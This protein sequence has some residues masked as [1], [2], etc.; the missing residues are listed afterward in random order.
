MG[1]LS[2][3]LARLVSGGSLPLPPPQP[4]PPGGLAGALGGALGQQ[5]HVARLLQAQ[6]AAMQQQIQ[7]PGHVFLP[8]LGAITRGPM[9]QA[10]QVRGIEGLPPLDV[11]ITDEPIIG[12]RTW[13]V[14][15]EPGGAPILTS[16]TR[17]E[18][19]PVFW[20]GPLFQA[21][22]RPDDYQPPVSNCPNQ[23]IHGVYAWRPLEAPHPGN[24]SFVYAIEG[25]VAL[26]GKVVVHEHGYRAERA[27]IRR[28]RLY[29]GRWTSDYEF[30][31]WLYVDGAT[32]EPHPI[33]ERWDA[34]RARPGQLEPDPEIAREL[35][36][37]YDCEVELATW[38]DFS[39]LHVDEPDDEPVLEVWCGN[40]DRDVRNC[41]CFD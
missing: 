38:P 30:Y 33:Y 40:C 5:S 23:M 20:H 29:P 39:A 28:L 8:G 26:F 9:T 41:V 15:R 16:H 37:R 3:L 32:A 17:R 36:A 19:K 27:L 34:E 1:H 35:E 21:E 2:D 11:R 10:S 7:Q 13:V 24:D 25:E 12:W 14:L 4:P 18:R 6:P 31:P 22:G